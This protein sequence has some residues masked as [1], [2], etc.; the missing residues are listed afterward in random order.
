[1]TAKIAE[2]VG[3]Q[4]VTVQQAELAQAM[5]TGVIDSYMS[6]A[7]TGYDTKTYEY[8]KVLRHPGLAAE[9]RGHRQQEGVRRARSRHA[10]RAEEAG[11]QAEERGWKLSQEKNKWYQEELAKNGMETV[12]PTVE[13]KE[14][15]SVIGKRML[16]D[17]LKKAG[18][19]GQA[20]IDAYRKQ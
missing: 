4:P 11:A 8:I 10:G 7:S 15:L 18:A 2:L 9:E 3:A 1:M 20:M 16:D 14:G 5:A 17:W 6:S 19:D 12:K 13:L